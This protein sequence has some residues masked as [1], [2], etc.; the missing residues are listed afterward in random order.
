MSTNAPLPDPSQ[1]IDTAAINAAIAQKLRAH[2]W[3]GRVLTGAAMSVGMLAILTG[4][5]LAWASASL[6]RPMEQL[7][8]QDYPKALA[9]SGAI[10]APK[11]NGEAKPPLTRAEL[12]FRHVQVTAAHGKALFI[13]AAAIVLLGA[14]TFL[15]LL[16]VIF[17]RQITL[18][19]INA[20]LELISS[21]IRDLQGSK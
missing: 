20:S 12:D 3:K 8:L 9:A 11:E 7:L 19:Q 14:G 5:L 1:R 4:I 13:A 2:R 6:I 17:N 21:Q 16:L 15:T 10:P 18:R